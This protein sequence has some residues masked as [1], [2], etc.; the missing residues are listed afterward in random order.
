MQGHVHCLSDVFMSWLCGSSCCSGVHSLI[1]HNILVS[2]LS[3]KGCIISGKVEILSVSTVIHVST[4][5][6]VHVI[7]VIDKL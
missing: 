3:C 6:L 2:I 4:M 5:L 1:L 7:V